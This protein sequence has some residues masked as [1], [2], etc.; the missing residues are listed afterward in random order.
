MAQKVS[1]IQDK[2]KKIQ[3]KEAV[4]VSIAINSLSAEKQEYFLQVLTDIESAA[5]KKEK[6]KKDD[7]EKGSKAK[8]E[9]RFLGRL[10]AKVDS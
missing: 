9:G 2:I 5:L 6:T 3:K 7:E 4:S 10:K 1:T 8:E